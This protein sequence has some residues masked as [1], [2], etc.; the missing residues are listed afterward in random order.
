MP[1]TEIVDV[2]SEWEALLADLYAED[3]STESD[4]WDRY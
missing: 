3:Y 4:G 1:E 2:D